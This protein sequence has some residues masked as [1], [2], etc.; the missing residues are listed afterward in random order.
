MDLLHN[1]RWMVISD[2]QCVWAYDTQ[3]EAE[4][5]AANIRQFQ[6]SGYNTLHVLQQES[7]CYPLDQPRKWEYID[8]S[9]ELPTDVAIQ[10]VRSFKYKVNE[11][12]SHVHGFWNKD[13]YVIGVSDHYESRGKR[14]AIYMH[15]AHVRFIKEIG[16]KK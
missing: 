13:Y 10:W 5:H 3:E 11:T 9:L 1:R 12:D 6:V 7:G 4:E 2:G 16:D 8:Y 14:I 15:D